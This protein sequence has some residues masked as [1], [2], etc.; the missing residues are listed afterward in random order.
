MKNFSLIFFILISFFPK[1]EAQT[2]QNNIKKFERRLGKDKIEA[3]NLLVSD[4]ENKLQ[5][6]YPNLSIEDAYKQFL[7]EV[8]NK[9]FDWSDF[10]FQTNSTH[11]KY[12][13]SGLR[14]DL[15]SHDPE[16]GMQINRLGSY[17]KALYHI[18]SNADKLTNKYYTVRE[19]AGVI[20]NKL[21]ASI[22]LVNDPDFT[23][24]FHK[25]FVVVEFSY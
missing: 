14:K 11:K 22:V 2:N 20:Q 23:N 3:L 8:K 16:L 5:K 19:M 1:V 25:R 12:L 17:M 21:F 9:T 4:F 13:E 15:Y 18:K 6:L 10:N 24:Y 7:I